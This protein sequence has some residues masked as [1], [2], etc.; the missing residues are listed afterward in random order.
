MNRNV[1]FTWLEHPTYTLA[2]LSLS[3]PP[4]KDLDS[5]I[6]LVIRK[7]LAVSLLWLQRRKQTLTSVVLPMVCVGG[8]GGRE[9]GRP[10]EKGAGGVREAG[11]E[12]AGTG[13][14]KVA[15]SWR[16]REKIMQ[17]C[18]IFRNRKNAKGREPKN[19]G[20]EPGLKGTGSGRFKPPC[21]RPNCNRSSIMKA[22]ATVIITK[23]SSLKGKRMTRMFTIYGHHGRQE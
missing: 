3:N 13:I 21:P 18:A 14:P 5:L 9:T 12:G 8:T 4:K 10:G 11:E 22:V 7:E 20:R 1:Q 6:T 17:H 23:V 15:G 19:T 16:K 2:E